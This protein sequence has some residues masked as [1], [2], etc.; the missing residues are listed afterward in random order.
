MLLEQD[1][2]QC[3]RKLGNAL[4]VPQAAVTMV[5]AVGILRPEC[6]LDP[7]VVAS[8]SVNAV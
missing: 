2:R 1:D 5:H 6:R 7:A 3:M 4:A 8:H